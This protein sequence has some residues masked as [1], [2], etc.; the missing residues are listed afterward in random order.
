MTTTFNTGNPIGSTSLKDFSDDVSN[1]D[2]GLNSQAPSFY[3][4][5]GKRRET[6]A[7][8]EARYADAIAG[9]G[10]YNLGDYTAGITLS[11]RSQTFVRNGIAYALAN[12]VV[13]P[14]T[15]TGDWASE[16]MNFKVIGDS[17]V[18][19]DVSNTADV[20]KGA[21]LVGRG[22]QVVG[23]L[24]AIRALKSTSVST[25]VLLRGIGLYTLDLGDT[26]SVDTGGSV[27]V[28]TDGGRWKFKGAS[29]T[30]KMFGA[31]GDGVTDDSAAFNAATA[32]ART[33]GVTLQFEDGDYLVPN[34]AVQSG[35][36]FW[37]GSC[38]AKLIGNIVFTD[39]TFPASADIAVPLDDTAPF[40]NVRGINFQS[41]NTKYALTV[42][43]QY[44]SSFIDCMRLADCRFF[45]GYGLRAVNL[46]TVELSGCWFYNS[47]I[48][49]R[50]EGCVNWSV[51]QCFWRNQVIAGVQVAENTTNSGR[52][53]GENIR[54]SLCE[55]D[56]CAIGVHLRR[57]MWGSFDNCLFDYCGLPLRVEG[58]PFTKMSKC[59][60]GAAQLTNIT[61]AN[62]YVAPPTIGSAVYVHPFVDGSVIENAG[63][64]A[65]NCEFI[66][67]YS[68]SSQPIMNIDGYVSTDS[69]GRHVER[70]A[71][72]Q[73]KFYATANHTS[74]YL[75]NLSYCS[76]TRLSDNQF[77]SYNISNTLL[78]P[79][80]VNNVTSHAASGSDTLLCRQSDVEVK[81]VYEVQSFNR[82]NMLDNA[83]GLLVQSTDGVNCMV[84]RGSGNDR[85]DVYAG[86]ALRTI[87]VGTPGSGGTGYRTLIVPN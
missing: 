69:A 80:N 75:L 73:N 38:N 28:A 79:F 60:A 53:G 78:A 9:L 24:S 48:G 59:Y 21:A 29:L 17:S 56:C 4:R 61:S 39:L 63:L 26:T 32:A 72:S 66:N 6:Y 81:S 86:G 74:N 33:L 54:F 49:M 22:V 1:F 46:I 7:G 35:R 71:L 52:K 31:K 82:I 58:S 3:D 18:R 11:S 67:Y 5:F 65:N 50:L 37:Q 44:G 57:H 68:G 55:F 12:A 34:A 19:S 45:G 23:D 10:F 47:K 85:V 25:D 15:T 70:V 20:S 76:D 62:G 83:L 42:T 8:L 16:S 40:F 51:S 2:E 84:V 30:L 14:Y 64:T 43:A 13:P 77:Q 36:T 27:I 87:G 41:N